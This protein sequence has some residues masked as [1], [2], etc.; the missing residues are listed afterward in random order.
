[1]SREETRMKQKKS[2]FYQQT[3]ELL[4][5]ALWSPEKVGDDLF[6]DDQL[7]EELKGHAVAALI[8]PILDRLNMP[9]DLRKEWEKLVFMQQAFAEYYQVIQLSLPLDIPYVI[10]KGISAAQ[11]YP[12]P[13]ERYLGDIDIMTA[14]EDTIEACEMLVHNDW[15]E[16]TSLDDEKRGRHRVFKKGLIVVEVHS[17]FASM[18]NPNRAEILDNLIIDS[19]NPSHILPDMVNGLV[20]IDHINQHM[21]QGLGLRQIIDWMMF[22]DKCLTD[23][24]WD[25]FSVLAEATG[26]EALAVTTTRMCEMYLGLPIHNWCRDASEQLCH[27]LMEY[28]M[29]CGDFGR[30]KSMQEEVAISRAGRLRHPIRLLKEL[31]LQGEENC[32]LAGKPSLKYFAWAWQ[33]VQI[34]KKTP[35]LIGRYSDAR[36]R[37]RMFDALGVKCSEKGLVTYRDGKYVIDNKHV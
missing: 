31:Q 35:G 27:D 14:R 13:N 4:K 5:L 8:Q 2:S 10:L 18:N 3:L 17:F 19:I 7:F 9:S 30:M 37:D 33:G 21:E 36:R 24:R 28:V 6:V 34:I 15:T 12:K 25:E 16:I 32:E 20:L 26:F 29:S 23:E 22:A 11:Y 1:M